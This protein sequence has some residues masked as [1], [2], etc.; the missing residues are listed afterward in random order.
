MRTLPADFYRILDRLIDA[1]VLAWA[2]T[3]EL[4]RGP[5]EALYLTNAN[6][7]FDRNGRTYL[8]F[9]VKLAE[10]ADSGEGDLP[11]TVLTLSNVGRYPMPY[12]EARRFDQAR[13]ILELAYL[14]DLT[15]NVLRIDAYGQ[16]AT[17]TPEAVNINLG[18]PNLFEQLYPGRRW[19]RAEAFPGIPRNLH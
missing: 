17:A 10:I 11:T 13:V 2:I 16:S 15:I 6:R 1:G 7:S 8:P 9:P 14:P 18:S 3:I 5:A 12:V 4:T 19:I